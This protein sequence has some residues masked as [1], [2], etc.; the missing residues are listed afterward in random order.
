VPPD[1]YGPRECFL[2]AA[3]LGH[4]KALLRIG[5]AH[6]N[7]K[8]DLGCPLDNALSLQY[9]KLASSLGEPE[10]DLEISTL[11]GYGGA[12]IRPNGDLAYYYARLAVEG[13]LVEGYFQ[14]GTFHELGIGVSRDPGKALHL[15][16]IA[17]ANGHKGARKR[18]D[19]FLTH[20]RR[21]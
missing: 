16:Q 5:L 8:G 17:A 6:S 1:L 14:L 2:K 9:L 10:A 15:Y 19:G 18:I 3:E 11:F 4:S 13:N 21:P 12:G 7:T 20:G